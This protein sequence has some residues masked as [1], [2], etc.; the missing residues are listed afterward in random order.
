MPE[1]MDETALEW[2]QIIP[3]KEAYSAGVFS[4]E[5]GSMP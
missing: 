4:W 3:W 5:S 2:K 1:I